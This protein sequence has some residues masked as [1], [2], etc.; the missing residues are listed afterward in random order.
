MQSRLPGQRGRRGGGEGSGWDVGT[1]CGQGTWWPSERARGGIR[2]H[3]MGSGHVVGYGHVV[4]SGCTWW[5]Q[6][7]HVVGSGWARGGIRVGTWW[8][9]CTWWDQGARGGISARGGIRTRGGIWARGG[10]RVHVV[11]SRLTCQPYN[12]YGVSCSLAF[13]SATWRPSSYLAPVKPVRLRSVR[14]CEQAR[15]QA[16]H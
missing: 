10:I 4:G 16:H 5:D 15:G 7:G 3:V 8:D 1:C 12:V 11:G 14:F 9:Q 13:T 6:L 2:V